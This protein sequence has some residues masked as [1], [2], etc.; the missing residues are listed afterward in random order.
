MRCITADI[1]SVCVETRLTGYRQY[2]GRQQQLH[3][4]HKCF[5]LKSDR[6]R[7]K[8]EGKLE[9][10]DSERQKRDG[11]MNHRLIKRQAGY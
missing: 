4:I 6:N 11:M 8:R 9:R 3:R 1:R 7:E 10:T 5:L 2:D